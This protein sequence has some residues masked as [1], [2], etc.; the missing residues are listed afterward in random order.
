MRLIKVKDSNDLGVFKDIID[1]QVVDGNIEAVTINKDGKELRIT[2]AGSYTNAIKLLV[3]EP[4]QERKMFRVK[5]YYM[6]M[7]TVPKEF[8]DE[9]EAK[10][11]IIEMNG[12][13]PYGEEHSLEVEEF[14]VL[15]DLTNI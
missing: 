13:L 1:I 9:Y 10:Q 14:T 11:Y 8:D 12:K 6:G 2:S 4:K 5:G 15:V 7:N 3:E